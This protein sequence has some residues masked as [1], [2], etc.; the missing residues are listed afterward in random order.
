MDPRPATVEVANTSR[1][2]ATPVYQQPAAR[3]DENG[4][5]KAQTQTFFGSWEPPEI[6]ETR[7]STT[8]RVL[9]Q[10]QGRP[11]SLA[12]RIYGDAGL[13]WVI[14][15][16]NAIRFPLVD[17]VAGMNVV[18]PHVDDVT[19]ALASTRTR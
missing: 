9:P 7:Q 3:V 12:Y 2:R 10:E 11:D 1:Y 4:T 15:L 18:C 16:R 13:W 19:A 14:C 6:L 5:I 17:L 8:V